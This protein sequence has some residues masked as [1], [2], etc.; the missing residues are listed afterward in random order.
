[1]E[2]EN[3]QK[4]EFTADSFREMVNGFQSSRIILTAYELHIFTVLGEKLRTSAEVAMNTGTD[5]R[6]MDR[7]MYALC[8]IGLLEK[9]GNCFQNRKFALDHLVSGKPGY[10]TGLMHTV[11][12]WDSWST[13]TGA[14]EN[15]GTARTGSVDERG[16]D[17]L[18]AFISAMHE[19][20][21]ISA[22]KVIGLIDL[23]NTTK[24]L[25]VGG[26]S[27]AFSMAF[28]NAKNEIKATVFDLP[29]VVPITKKYIEDAGMTDKIICKT[30]DYEID[31][32]GSGYD[33]IF[34][35]AIVH[36]NSKA[37]NKELIKKCCNALNQ[38]GQV[39]IQDFIM[40]DDRTTPAFGAVFALNMLVN[41]KEG[42]SYTESE[43]SGWMSEAG[44][45]DISRK[46]TGIGT[47][48]VF[49]WKV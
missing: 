43:I 23:S 7:L 25:D 28:I 16:K 20:A 2:K 21:V 8:T 14:V 13:L 10:I 30:G 35:S 45:S 46:D 3:S 41:T 11:H 1:M 27:A 40:D 22:D 49:G 15:G 19:R 12:L 17:W 33:L 4:N 18:E 34:L 42:D 47:G 48:L 36:S 29:N 9:K 37:S 5:R 31:E 24:V 26:G 38:G 39:V 32:L 44:L 6:G